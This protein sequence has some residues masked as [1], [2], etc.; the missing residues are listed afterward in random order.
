MRRKLPILL[1]ILVL[2]SLVLAACGGGGQS[3]VTVPT[4][5]AGKTNPLG[6]DAATAGKTTFDE[7][8]ASCHGTTGAGDGPAAAG[9]DPKP[10]NLVEA[11]KTVGDDFLFWRVNEGG[12]MEPFNSAM[13]SWKG[14]FS[15]EEIWQVITYIKTLK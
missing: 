1:G 14:I 8:C 15:E 2:G 6:A 4:E 11:V 9:L 12:G 7:R 5:Y 3:T 10:A 13:P